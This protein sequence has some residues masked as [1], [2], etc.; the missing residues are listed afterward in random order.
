MRII[1]IALMLVSVLTGCVNLKN[2]PLVL[3]KILSSHKEVFLMWLRLMWQLAMESG[4]TARQDYISK[5][6]VPSLSKLSKSN[7]S[8][9]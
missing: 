3:L 7:Q 4:I 1:C 6:N 9:C 8:L 5:P 2:T